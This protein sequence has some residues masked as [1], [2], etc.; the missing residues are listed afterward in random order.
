MIKAISALYE[1]KNLYNKCCVNARKMSQELT[2][3]NV[4]VVLISLEKNGCHNNR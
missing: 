2:W 3:E 1:D 4:F